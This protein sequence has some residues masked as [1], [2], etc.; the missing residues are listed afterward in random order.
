MLVEFDTVFA[1]VV[2]ATAQER[3]WL[4]RYLSV[5]TGKWGGGIYLFNPY[6]GLGQFPAGF[7]SLVRKRAIADGVPIEMLDARKAP[8]RDDDAD[9]SWL[10]D[11]QAEAVARVL[12]RTRGIIHSPTGSGKGELV[13]ALARAVR[14]R[15]L[16]VVHRTT[17]VSAQATRFED[18][19]RQ[20]GVDLGEAGRIGD[21]LFTLGDRLT[22]A[23]FQTLDRMD[24]EARREML[25]GFGGLMVDEAH[26]TPAASHYSMLMDCPAY[27]RVGLS[28]TP[29]DRNDDRDPFTVAALGPV[30][31]HIETKTL[32]ERGVLARPIV[33]MLK[34]PQPHAKGSY[35]SVYSKCIAKSER[36]NAAVVSLARRASKPAIL[37]VKH[38]EHGKELEKQ[39][40]NSGIAAEFVHGMHSTGWREATLRRLKQGKTDVVIATVI[41]QEGVDVPELRSVVNA[42]GQLSVIATLQKIGRGMRV[43]RDHAGNVREGGDTFE[44]WDVFDTGNATLEKHA[45]ARRAAYVAQGHDTAV[46]DL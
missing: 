21:G 15:W 8:P 36:R 34:V 3:S 17:L 1:R 29:L 18:R 5:D 23:T 22:C 9:L 41:F 11:Y 39:L 20:H 12:E 27:Y 43:D 37:F 25:A 13:I 2:R 31:F 14:T 10:R 44:V 33:R 46:I 6:V 38:V 45:R 26:T 19:N 7:A 40:I 42:S 4:E 30:I 16:F 32:V 35:A 28:G 24:K